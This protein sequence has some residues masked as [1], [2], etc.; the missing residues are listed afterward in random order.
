MSQARL[1]SLSFAAVTA[2]FIGYLVIWLPGPAAGL[3]LLGVEI[4]EWIKF[5][6]VG[7]ERNLFYLP[8]ITL[9]LILALMTCSWPDGR[10]QN[11]IMRAFAV[12]VSLLAFPAI[13]A[14]RFEPL[15]EWLLR[16]LLIFLV[17]VVATATGVLGG[18]LLIF[19]SRYLPTILLGLIG[20]L[21][22]VLPTW[23]YLKTR[24]LVSQA[25]GRP[26]GVGVGVWLNGLGHLAI[27]AVALIR[28]RRLRG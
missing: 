23:I 25:I 26:I 28:V 3:E 2:I 9:G 19:P 17:F 5:L 10:W 12:G 22:A 16:L 14:I 6:G 1:R 15:S 4:G 11:W 18:R 20:V 7:T 24:P 13:E 27:T 8:P 21:G